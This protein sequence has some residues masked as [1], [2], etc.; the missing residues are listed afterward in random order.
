MSLIENSSERLR[1]TAGQDQAF[2]VQ[3]H[4]GARGLLPENS[5]PA[6]ER[7]TRLGVTTL[8]MDTVISRDGHVVVSHEPWFSETISSHPDGRPVTEDEARSLRLYEMTYEEISRFDC[9]RRG[10]PRFPDQEAMPTRKPLLSEVI[11]EAESLCASLQRAPI[12]YNI[13][14]KSTPAGDGIYHPGPEEFVDRLLDVL[15]RMNVLGRSC[16]QS[17]DPRTLRVLE[18]RKKTAERG[19]IF[20]RS[21]LLV[22]AD[23]GRDVAS[24]V[25]RLG[26]VPDYYSPDFCIVDRAL[27]AACDSH[28]MRVLPWTVN[29]PDDMNRM[30]SLGVAG[31]ITDY[32]DRGMELIKP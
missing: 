9:G 20:P 12:L 5:L 1:Q 10:N 32:P 19:G 14:T 4:R 29:D 25:E 16:I 22:T 18:A 6:F 17:F 24:A 2:D 23:T 8:E 3:G 31:L 27:V 13:E 21:A 28:G 11:R 15:V 30:I 7:A 26:F